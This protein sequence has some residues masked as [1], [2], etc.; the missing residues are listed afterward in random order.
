MLLAVPVFL[1]GDAAL[2]LAAGAAAGA[3][4]MWWWKRPRK[5]SPASGITA[6]KAELRQRTAY[7]DLLIEKSPLAIVVLDG[8]HLCEHCN[9][10]F[11]KLFGYAEAEIRGRNVDEMIVGPDVQGEAT[12][13]TQRV[14]AGET[15]HFFGR[16]R[17]KDGK[18]VDVECHGVPLV[19]D[20]KLTA[21]YG[22][23][24]DITGRRLAEK[25]LRESEERYRDLFENAR[26][27]ILV[28]APDG[29][30][31]YV[32]RAWRE[33]LGYSEQ[34]STGLSLFSVVHPESRGACQE[35]VRRLLRG[36]PMERLD[37]HFVA[38]D[39]R[40]VAAEGSCSCRFQSG[41]PVFLRAIFSD[42][43][44]RHK[45]EEE[46]TALNETLEQRVLE[47]TQQLAAVNREL[48]LRN[49]E[50]E[51]ANRLKSQFLAS[52]SH[53]L[54]TPLNA[55]IGFSELLSEET[56]GPMNE[57]QRR[58]IEHVLIG[59]R[60]LLQLINDILDLAKVESGQLLLRP[61]DFSL[62]EALPE[63]LS[64]IKPLAMNKRI[65]VESRV[66]PGVRLYADRI[67]VKQILYNLLSNAVKFTAEGGQVWVDARE[68][69]ATVCVTVSDTGVGIPSEEHQAIFNEFYQV[70]TTTKGVKEGTG[71]GLA[72][73]RRLV[74]AHEG[75][76]W[77][78]SEPG[79]GSRFSFTVRAGT[80]EAESAVSEARDG[81]E[82]PAG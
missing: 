72:I 25:L 77:V 52:M 32:N 79:K 10:A 38:K 46:I 58:Y 33:T 68:A 60:H 44:E 78:E 17:R 4:G 54:R 2:W 59:A 23:Y 28:A 56:A 63:V 45:A 64:T 69:N 35:Y 34:D 16:R 20:G 30:L 81:S 47:R 29:T 41:Q 15:V 67:R 71:L 57:K 3:L 18:L 48:E 11:E 31:L 61:E 65:V 80:G 19:V 12:G 9:P 49:R 26:E 53:E 42:V 21:V 51:R 22:L 39:G 74:E 27:M 5:R 70:G 76:I 37:V 55:V 50:V 8:R 13:Y 73:S 24:Q 43:T 36:E 66:G 14:L 6:V 40:R 7:L 82:R 1:T 62:A 75:N